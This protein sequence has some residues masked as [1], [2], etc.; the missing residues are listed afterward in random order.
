MTLS[1]DAEHSRCEEKPLS[2]WS[3]QGWCVPWLCLVGGGQAQFPTDTGP[4]GGSRGPPADRAAPSLLPGG[5]D[6]DTQAG[7]HGLATHKG[8]ERHKLPSQRTPRPAAL[9]G[10]VWAGLRR[11]PDFP[12]LGCSPLSL[13]KAQLHLESG[14]WVSPNPSLCYLTPQPALTQQGGY[15]FDVGL[16]QG[17]GFRA[18]HPHSAG[19]ELGT[20]TMRLQQPRPRGRKHV[21][22]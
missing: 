3:L 14:L 20:E 9:G 4:G 10:G 17:P 15:V 7:S 21:F 8:T 13:V 16:L 12:H 2:C 1:Q 22:L 5:S 6:S 19:T 18:S 11:H